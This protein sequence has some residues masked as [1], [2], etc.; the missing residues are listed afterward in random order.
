M[1]NSSNAEEPEGLGPNVEKKCRGSGTC[2]SAYVAGPALLLISATNLTRFGHCQAAP[3][4]ITRSGA[5]MLLTRSER[6][7]GGPG[8]SCTIS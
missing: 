2:S 7:S 6:T 8:L 4:A 5:G 3:P 1:A